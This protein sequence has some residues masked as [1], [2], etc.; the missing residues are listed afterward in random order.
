MGL[1]LGLVQ[2]VD[3]LACGAEAEQ[4]DLLSRV[5]VRV[6]VRGLG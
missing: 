3:L 4:V 6:R 2:L 1:G 5:R